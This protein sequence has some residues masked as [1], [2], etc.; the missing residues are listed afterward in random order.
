[1][2]IDASV[3]GEPSLE[4]LLDQF[5]CVRVINANALDLSRAAEPPGAGHPL[6]TDESGRDVL[7][8]LLAGDRKS[9]V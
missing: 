1:M 6:G 9:V 7:G 5:V 8:R 2:G 4:P 3:L